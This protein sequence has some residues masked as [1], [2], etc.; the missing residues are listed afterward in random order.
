[1]DMPQ[2]LQNLPPEVLDV[3]RFF[4]ASGQTSAH[5]DEIIERA[6]LSDRGFGKAIRRLVTSTYLVMDGDQ[7]Y[8]LSDAGRRAV[9]GLLEYDLENPREAGEAP[10]L[11]GEARLAERRLVV[12]IPRTLAAGDPAAVQVGFEGA[13]DGQELSGPAPVV[14]RFNTL[15]AEAASPGEITLQVGNQPVQ[16]TFTLT[17]GSFTHARLRVQLFQSD[18]FGYE[19][20]PCGG[21]YVDV[22]VAAVAD[23]ARA[24]Y[25][26]DVSIRDVSG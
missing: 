7:V 6:G 4:G 8:R 17:P 22:P 19:I 2:N 25:G 10:A 24:A 15:H 1:M 21:L 14:V 5:A 3:L 12:A 20:E 16:H 9:A 11:P 18:E 13:E 23:A 26:I